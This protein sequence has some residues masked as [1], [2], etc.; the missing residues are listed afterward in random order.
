MVYV[1]CT[2]TLCQTGHKSQKLSKL[3]AIVKVVAP[4][5]AVF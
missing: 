5:K 3:V 1:T 4:D 2:T